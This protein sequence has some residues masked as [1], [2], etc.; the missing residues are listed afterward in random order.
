MKVLLVDDSRASRFFFVHALGC[1]GIREEDIVQS[2]NGLE[3]WENLKSAEEQ[4]TFTLMITDLHMP[5]LD[6]EH[7]LMR[8]SDLPN[9]PPVIVVTSER[10]QE[11]LERIRKLGADGIL[12]KPFS[13]EQFRDLLLSIGINVSE[14]CIESNGQE[15]IPDE[16]RF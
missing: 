2:A 6:G 10:R 1:L 4:G 16:E 11:P 5:G 13:P 7:L 9:R 3:A 8:M 14:T 15:D 12:S